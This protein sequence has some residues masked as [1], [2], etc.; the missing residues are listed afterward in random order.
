MINFVNFQVYQS[1]VEFLLQV[2][3]FVCLFF[4]QFIKQAEKMAK[5]TL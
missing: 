1:F 3:I 4:A 5:I 2:G